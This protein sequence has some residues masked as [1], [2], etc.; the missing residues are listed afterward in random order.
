MKYCRYRRVL[1][2]ALGLAIAFVMS[3]LAEAANDN[4]GVM[5]PQSHPHGA[6][7]G[8]WNARWW[9]WLYQTPVNINPEFSDPGTP[10]ALAAVDCSAGQTGKVWFL[11]GTFSPTTPAGEPPASNVYRTCSISPGIFLYFPLLNDE[12]DNLTCKAD[13]SPATLGL[14]AVELKNAATTLIDDI[15]SG[16]MSA[17]IDGVSIPGLADAHS[18]YRS[19]SPWFSYTLPSDNVGQFFAGPTGNPCKFPAGTQPP[20][21]GAIADGIYLMLA[22]LSPGVHHIH[23]GG[24][25][26]Y[27]GGNSVIGL[28]FTFVQ[29]INYTITV[30]P[31]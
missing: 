28:P 30:T 19:P 23:F 22:P 17:T 16:T 18:A 21:P 9:Q 6:T 15:V 2:G 4:P 26:D 5:P 10:N 29:N 20:V 27:P 24:K 1:I 31:G 3:P 7:Y 12:F 11:G 25:I 13:G 8:Q 14:S